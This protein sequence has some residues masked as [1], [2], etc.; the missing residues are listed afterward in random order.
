MSSCNMIIVV[1]TKAGGK[2]VCSMFKTFQIKISKHC[3]SR[4]FKEA[5]LQVFR[6]M[7]TEKMKPCNVV[8]KVPKLQ[9]IWYVK[10]YYQI[11]ELVRSNFSGHTNLIEERA[12]CC[13]IGELIEKAN[14]V[15]KIRRDSWRQLFEIKSN[16]IKFYRYTFL[17]K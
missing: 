6:N 1:V 7:V 4:E 13:D 5:N 11:E 3:N 16:G 17:R 12:T 15:R 9:E 2:H 10:G 14:S 8:Y